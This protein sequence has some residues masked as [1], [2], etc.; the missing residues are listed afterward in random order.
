LYI[1]ILDIFYTIETIDGHSLS[2]TKSHNIPV[3][4]LEKNQIKFVRASKVT[5]KHCLIILDQKV[6]VKNITIGSR[7]GF[8][9]PLTLTGYL[10]VN[11]ISTSVFPARYERIMSIYLAQENDSGP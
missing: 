8:F 7:V 10:L 11:N 3:Y 1:N 4:D 6:K 2:L 5:L 9:S